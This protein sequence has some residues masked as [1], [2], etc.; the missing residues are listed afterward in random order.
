MEEA[1]TGMNLASYGGLIAAVI[2]VTGGIKKLFPTWIGDKIVHVVVL[3]SYAL[4]VTAKLTIP[5]AFANV[6]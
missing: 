4:G 2:A 6:A 3:A 5:D 1:F